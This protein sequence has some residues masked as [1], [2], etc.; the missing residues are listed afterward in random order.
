MGLLDLLRRHLDVV[1]NPDGAEEAAEH[2]VEHL[3]VGGEGLC[4]RGGDHAHGAL[5]LAQLGA[6][7]A[8]KEHG[9][10]LA[11]QGHHLPGEQFDERRLAAAIG[12]QHHNALTFLDD[13]VVHV[14]DDAPIPAD[15]RVMQPEQLLSHNSSPNLKA[16]FRH[17]ERSERSRRIS[18]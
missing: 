4:E 9:R 14:Q 16:P 18:S 2:H 10:L 8:A 17:P 3:A 12:A 7:V 6:G 15:L 13:E 11:P 5:D 1:G